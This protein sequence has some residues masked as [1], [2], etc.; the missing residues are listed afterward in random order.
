MAGSHQRRRLHEVIRRMVRTALLVVDVQNDLFHPDGA[1]AGDFPARAAP[2]LDALRHL[3]VL[4]LE[5]AHV[6]DARRLRVA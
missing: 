4:L 2:M 6:Q 5:L 1:L 3:Q